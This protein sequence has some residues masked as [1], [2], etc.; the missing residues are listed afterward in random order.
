[1]PNPHELQKLVQDVADRLKVRRVSV[2][3]VGDMILDSAIEGVPGG[4]HPET[5]VAI[6]RE[7]TAQESI[8]GAANI[9]L[10]LARLGVEV[11][12]FGVIG[13][14]LPGRQLE[15]LLD[16]QPFADHLVVERGWPTPRKDWIYERQG[17]K[18]T[19]VQR[20]NYDR[21]LSAHARE[22]L[23][24]EFRAR[25]TSH[26]DVVILADHGLGSI[27]PES[28]GLIPLAHERQAKLVAIPRT[29]V[30][31]GQPLDAIVINA[32]EM[33][34]FSG[35]EETADPRTLAAR[36]AR[37][38]A[39]HVFLTLMEEG[40]LVCPAGSRTPGTQVAGYEVENFQW[41]G[42]RD[43]ATS[44]VAVGLAL[45]LDPLDIGRLANVFRHLVACQRGNGRV[46]WRDV[47]RFVGLEG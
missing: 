6:L 13:S 43:M 42:A 29:T 3:V 47:F 33:R 19:L 12:L 46:V 41:M 37:E 8:G 15:N 5:K 36:Y 25:C 35:A 24:G 30:L 44:L 31:R 26:V 40:I 20:I 9:A 27:G 32:S 23:V 38:Y 2:A 18:V 1:M 21:P 14:D 45:G 16:R 22:E 39:Q 4:R 10:A 11:A 28:L 34:L 7:A 17:S